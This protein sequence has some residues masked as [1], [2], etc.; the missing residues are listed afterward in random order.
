MKKTARIAAL[1]L[2]A[3]A[4]TLAA[5][6]AA[7]A[8]PAGGEATVTGVIWNDLNAN[9]LRD[10]GEPGIKGAYVGVLGGSYTTTAEDGGYSLTAPSGLAVQVHAA[11][12]S[13]WGAVWGPEAEGGSV[14]GHCT[15]ESGA[16]VLEP[17]QVLSGYDGGFV[18]S[19]VDY[20]PAPITLSPAKDVYAVG[21]VVEVLGGIGHEGPGCAQLFAEVQLPEGVTK[22]DRLGDL[23]PYMSDGPRTVTGW[24]A[25]RQAPGTPGAIGARF[26]V[27]SPL[28]AATITVKSAWFDSNPANDSASVQL[29][30]S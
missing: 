18:T 14:F 13:G 15:G 3:A 20:S 10:A 21:D 30:A 28:S 2:T 9:G 11:D 1:A 7:L 25:D 24:T 6:P 8:G 27:D 26:V 17:G 4:A 16:V 22:L 29:N 23:R 19:K 5:A 12:R